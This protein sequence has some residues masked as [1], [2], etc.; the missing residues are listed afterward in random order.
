MENLEFS[1]YQPVEFIQRYTKTILK[2]LDAPNVL[3]QNQVRSNKSVALIQWKAPL[4]DWVKLNIDGASRGNPGPAGCGGVVRDSAGTWLASFSAKLG[5]CTSVK[6]ELM[7]LV[8]GLK[9]V[10]DKGFKNIIID[11]DSK[12]IVNT[13]KIPASL[14][15]IAEWK[16]FKL[17]F[18]A[19]LQRI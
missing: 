5:V 1:P 18:G 9:V 4:D 17:P 19:L 3:A 2:A 15:S 12:L 16:F 11:M 10:Q 14:A 13:M 7:A 6:A 8:H